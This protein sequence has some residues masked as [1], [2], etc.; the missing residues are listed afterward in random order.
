M[1]ARACV[2]ECVCEAIYCFYRKKRYIC[3]NF[4]DR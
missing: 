3:L 4:T 2:C 1:C